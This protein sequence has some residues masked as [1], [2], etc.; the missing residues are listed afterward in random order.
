[1]ANENISSSWVQLESKGLNIQGIEIEFK[2]NVKGTAIDMTRGVIIKHNSNSEG[3]NYIIKI[4]HRH[5]KGAGWVQC[6]GQ[7]SIGGKTFVRC[8]G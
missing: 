8:L 4:T 2:V 6:S 1:M 7:L 5:Y 3:I